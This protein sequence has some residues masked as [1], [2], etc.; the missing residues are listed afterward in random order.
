MRR[1]L[2]KLTQLLTLTVLVLASQHSPAQSEPILNTSPYAWSALPVTPVGQVRAAIKKPRPKAH[3]VKLP[4]PVAKLFLDDS[5]NDYYDD[6][7][8]IYVSYSRPEVVDP[9]VADHEELSDEIRLRLA[10]ATNRAL[11]RHREIWG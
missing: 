4:R 6:V 9:E 3:P 7:P 5:N 2:C 10:I 11:R 8:D 1:S